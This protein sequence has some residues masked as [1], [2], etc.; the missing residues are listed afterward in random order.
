MQQSNTADLDSRTDE[1]SAPHLTPYLETAYRSILIAVDSSDHSNRATD[2]AIEIGSLY[3]SVIT[4]SHVYAAKMH[5]L[6][7]KQME[8][9]LPEQFKEEDELERQRDIH[10][11]LI[12][13]G[14]SILLTLI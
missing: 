9:G 11:S 12:T 2:D 3:Q 6:R 7:F 10:D 14:L 1:D 8:G 4:A 13:R 5:D